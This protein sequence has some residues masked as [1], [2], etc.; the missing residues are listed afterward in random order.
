MEE[1]PLLDLIDFYES[2]LDEM[3][4]WDLPFCVPM[5]EAEKEECLSRAITE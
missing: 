4:I 1:E 2:Q 3:G 5:T